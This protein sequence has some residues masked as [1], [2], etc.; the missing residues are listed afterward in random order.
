M[1]DASQSHTHI[2]LSSEI[3]S[4]VQRLPPAA[5]SQVCDVILPA[6]ASGNTKTQVT[7]VDIALWSYLESNLAIIC[8]SVP[9]VKA[10]V[11]RIILCHDN[12][13]Y[14]SG[15]SCPTRNRIRHQSQPLDSTIHDEEQGFGSKSFAITLEH[16][17]EMRSYVAA[18]DA[19]Y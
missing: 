3:P 11:S 1:S 12:G 16:S 18:N 8:G 9:T 2:R 10:F 14:C 13:T 5:R 4:R 6:Q 19:G 7:G 15:T 17:I